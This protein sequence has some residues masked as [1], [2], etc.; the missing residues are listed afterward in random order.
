MEEKPRYAKKRERRQ[1]EQ[2]RIRSD[3]K[4]DK[5]ETSVD[6]GSHIE[7][8]NEAPAET[9]KT[10]LRK[11]RTDRKTDPN[12]IQCKNKHTA[13]DTSNNKKTE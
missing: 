13:G 4:G 7:R 9:E 10:A 2:R 5:D 3:D 8:S 11:T 6:K 1:A 12:T